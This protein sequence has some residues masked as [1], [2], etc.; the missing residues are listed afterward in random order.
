M[1]QFLIG[2]A[3]AISALTLASSAMAEDSKEVA[4]YKSQITSIITTW[5]FGLSTHTPV[6]AKLK[7]DMAKLKASDPAYNEKKDKAI[8][9]LRL[10]GVETAGAAAQI[11]GIPVHVANKDES[12]A[13]AGFIKGA[14][15]DKTRSL[16]VI[17]IVADANWHPK[18]DTD[19]TMMVSLA[20]TEN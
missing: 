1:K 12:S 2:L 13:L 11:S 4:N 17:K 20:V 16:R 6:F 14:V 8:S 15:A 18:N 7:E 5:A 9:I 10:M 3:V 19:G